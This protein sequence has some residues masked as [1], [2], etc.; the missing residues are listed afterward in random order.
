MSRRP[1]PETPALIDV[2][3]LVVAALLVTPAAWQASQGLL[4][5]DQV[6]TR[7]LFVALGCTVVL[8]F[9]RT[10]WPVLA[11]ER[12]ATSA[13]ASAEVAPGQDQVDPG[14]SQR[15]E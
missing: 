5:V 10:V 11:G 12:N 2:R 6:L 14:V 1:A 9:V 15:Q 8:A 4:S 7:Y 3:V 13:S